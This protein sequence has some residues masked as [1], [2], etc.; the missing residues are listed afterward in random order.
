MSQQGHESVNLEVLNLMEQGC[1]WSSRRSM[2][3]RTAVG[4]NHSV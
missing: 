3:G 4:I 1:A 2:P